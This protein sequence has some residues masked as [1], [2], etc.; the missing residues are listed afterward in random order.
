[1]DKPISTN[2]ES[3]RDAVSIQILMKQACGRPGDFLKRTDTWI[4]ETFLLAGL[5][6]PTRQ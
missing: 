5:K 6:E 4:L 1:M 3:F 2:V